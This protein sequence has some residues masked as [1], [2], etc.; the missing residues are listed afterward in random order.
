MKLEL[1]RKGNYDLIGY[2]HRDIDESLENST[3]KSPNSKNMYRAR[4]LP[5]LLMNQ[6][7]DP[8]RWEKQEKVHKIE[9]IKRRL[10]KVRK[11]NL[12][13]LSRKQE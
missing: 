9:E 12:S 13:S 8:Y 1:C 4:N 7:R 5:H 2:L 11:N 3:E 6:Y 10:K